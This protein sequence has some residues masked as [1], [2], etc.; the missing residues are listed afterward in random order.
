[1]GRGPVVDLNGF[2]PDFFDPDL[3]LDLSDPGRQRDLLHL[4]LPVELG[5]Q[6]AQDLS[7]ILAHRYHEDP[8]AKSR[9]FIKKV[10]LHCGIAV[11]PFKKGVI[12]GVLECWGKISIY[13]I[14]EPRG[15]PG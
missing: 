10:S 4:G 2:I 11:L 9:E 3:L 5:D 8:P 6:A 15:K 12:E 14:R 7:F 1:M 13:R